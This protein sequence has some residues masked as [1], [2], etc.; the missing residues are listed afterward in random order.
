M[1]V[2]IGWAS[3]NGVAILISTQGAILLLFTR[4]VFNY[5]LRFLGFLSDSNDNDNVD[6]DNNSDDSDSGHS[7]SY[8]NDNSSDIDDDDDKRHDVESDDSVLEQS[9]DTAR[10]SKS[11]RR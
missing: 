3:S 1:I 8:S 6:E 4:Q 11:A 9:Y 7:D 10:D 5:Y 2:D